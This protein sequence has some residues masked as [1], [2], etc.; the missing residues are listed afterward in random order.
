MKL[1]TLKFPQISR[2]FSASLFLSFFFWTERV[3]L[4]GAL[5]ALVYVNAITLQ[6]FQKQKLGYYTPV[7]LQPFSA[8]THTQVASTLWNVGLHTEAK[9]EITLAEELIKP[10]EAA[11]LG[12][13]TSPA[14]ILNDW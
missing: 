5:L 11:V 14:T 3:I 6:K 4:W 12:T 9:Q 2:L 10:D 13:N 1:P 7:L 8:K